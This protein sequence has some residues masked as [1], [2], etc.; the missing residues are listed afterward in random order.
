VGRLIGPLRLESRRTQR[1]EELLLGSERTGVGTTGLAHLPTGTFAPGY[2]HEKPTTRAQGVGDLGQH[3]RQILGL[4]V[5]ENV[6]RDDGI[7]GT[8][9]VVVDR[10]QP[11]NLFTARPLQVDERLGDVGTANRQP[12]ALKLIGIPSRAGANFEDMTRRDRLEHPR[13][14]PGEDTVAG[15]LPGVVGRDLLVR[16]NG[17]SIRRTL[18]EESLGTTQRSS[19]LTNGCAAR[20]A[21]P[22]SLRGHVS[23]AA[24]RPTSRG[25]DAVATSAS[26][27]SVVVAPDQ[28]FAETPPP[29]SHAA[30]L[31]LCALERGTCRAAGMPAISN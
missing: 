14:R 23:L 22:Q 30:R 3:G 4:H 16:L 15:G 26:T 2:R 8:T 7:V 18:L 24:E 21:R 11:I 10:V 28:P 25:S 20:T 19:T 1:V 27:C 31:H 17:P 5:L 29:A 9:E 6:Q 12:S 13:H